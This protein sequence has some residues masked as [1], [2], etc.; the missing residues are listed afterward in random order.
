MTNNQASIAANY[1]GILYGSKQITFG[2]ANRLAS[3]AKN[4][5]K[6]QA[7]IDEIKQRGSQ[8]DELLD[9]IGEELNSFGNADFEGTFKTI[10]LAVIENLNYEEIPVTMTKGGESVQQNWAIS[11]MLI[12]LQEL[13]II[14]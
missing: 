12:F 1:C 7:E 4:Y 9:S 14:K 5:Q 10:D 2:V 3:N 6:I 13:E 11:D 8:R